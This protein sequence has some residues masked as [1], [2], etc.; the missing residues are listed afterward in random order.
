L[1]NN[2]TRSLAINA[3]QIRELD[4]RESI[5]SWFRSLEEQFSV[6]Q[7]SAFIIRLGTSIGA[8]ILNVSTTPYEPYGAS[9]A[10]L[11]GQQHHIA[12]LDASHIAAHSYFD[13][14]DLRA[15]FRLEIEISTCGPGHPA[16]LIESVLQQTDAD[17]VQLDYR[18]RGL[19][20]NENGE[21]NLAGDK[22]TP[23]SLQLDGYKSA[24]MA[25]TGRSG[26]YVELTRV[27]LPVTISRLVEN[28]K[29]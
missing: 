28:M 27:G 9:A 3:Y 15:Q 7:L 4:D 26:C 12:H 16:S 10:L 11:V 13:A 20:W 6:D 24:H 19:V 8:K 1:F 25:T 22:L 29:D 5:E 18:V 23:E 2:V 21:P 14:N 17:F